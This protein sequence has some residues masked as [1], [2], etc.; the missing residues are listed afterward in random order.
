MC[1]CF[2]KKN[3]MYFCGGFREI[4]KVMDGKSSRTV[5]NECVSSKSCSTP[6]IWIGLQRYKWFINFGINELKGK[7]LRNLFKKFSYQLT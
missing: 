4:V 5:F 1:F 6:I 3:E 2:W 7:I